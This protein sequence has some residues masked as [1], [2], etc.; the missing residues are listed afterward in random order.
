MRIIVVDDEMITRVSLKNFICSE[1]PEYIVAG[2][3]TNGREAL[4]YLSTHPVDVVITDIRMPLMDG[5]ELSRMIQTTYPN[6]MVIIIS[7]YSE[8]EYAKQ[9]LQYNVSN[10][11]LKPIDFDELTASLKNCHRTISQ[12]Q[13]MSQEIDYS[14]E[15]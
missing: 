11:L 9:A 14:T 8:F 6:T 3:F 4:E 13:T 1:L 2:T 7:G 10:Y 5:L 12:L 15:E